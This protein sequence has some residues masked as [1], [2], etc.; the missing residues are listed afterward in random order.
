MILLKCAILCLEL[1]N[2]LREYYAGTYVNFLHQ[3]FQRM[4]QPYVGP[5]ARKTVAPGS[6][7]SSGACTCFISIQL[8]FQ[9]QIS[10]L[11]PCRVNF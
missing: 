1:L 4:E 8:K 11:N 2:T 7:H 10:K 6:Q 5:P 9:N 3:F